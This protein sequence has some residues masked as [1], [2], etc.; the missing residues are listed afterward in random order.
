MVTGSRW[1]KGQHGGRDRI[2]KGTG[3]LKGKDA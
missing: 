2:V 3:W 1:L